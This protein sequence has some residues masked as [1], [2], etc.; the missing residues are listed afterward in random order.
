MSGELVEDLRRVSNI[1]RQCGAQTYGFLQETEYA[2]GLQEVVQVIMKV[3]V[4]FSCIY[5]RM[6]LLSVSLLERWLFQRGIDIQ[7]TETDEIIECNRRS[8]EYDNK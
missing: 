6:K 3:Q 1:R 5:I 2:N 4:C 7:V 8:Y